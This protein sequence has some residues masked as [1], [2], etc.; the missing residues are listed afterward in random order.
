[1]S[2]SG[3][4]GGIGSAASG[5]DFKSLTNKQAYD[6]ASTLFSEGKISADQESSIQYFAQGANEVNVDGSASA[7]TLNDP[8]THNFISEFQNVV[9]WMESTPGSIGV[10]SYKSLVNIM[11][12]LQGSSETSTLR[13]LSLNA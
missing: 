9:T 7:N 13:G 1:M 2:I 4:S 10:G 11:Q 12:Q 8:G 3:I 5:Y 6:A